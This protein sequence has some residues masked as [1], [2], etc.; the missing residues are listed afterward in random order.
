[1]L[2]SIAACTPRAARVGRLAA[3]LAAAYA[4]GDVDAARVLHEA[5]GKLHVAPAA[6]QSNDGAAV[7]LLDDERRRRAGR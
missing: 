1:M 7:V 5:L 6:P 2:G 4:E 3:E